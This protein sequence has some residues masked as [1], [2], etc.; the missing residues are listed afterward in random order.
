MFDIQLSYDVDQALNPKE[1]NGDFHATL[2]YRVMEH[3]ASNVKNIKDSL[4]RIEKYI[5]GKSIDSNPNNIK[6]L[7]GISKAV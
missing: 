5:W 1:W 6:D 2:L 4:C 7:K 3:L